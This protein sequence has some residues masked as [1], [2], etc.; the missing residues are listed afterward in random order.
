M[1]ITFHGGV[2]EVGGSCVVIETNDAKIAL[3][4]GIKVE[5]KLHDCLPKDLDLVI[6]SHAHLDHS[7]ALLSLAETNTVVV[8]SEATRDITVELLRDL[9]KVQRMNGNEIPYS[10]RDVA[11]IRR[12]WW[13]RD[14]VA[15]PGMEVRLYPAGH[16]LGARMVDIQAE[17]KEVLYTGDFCLHSTE[18]LEGSNLEK[19]PRE[20]EAL[21]VESTYGGTNRCNRPELIKRLFIEINE[22]MDRKGN[23]LIP[24]FAFHRSQEMAKR[25]D[26]AMWGGDFPNYNVYVISKLAERITGH[27][28]H[29]KNL[30]TE[31]IRG[32]ENPFNYKYV[33]NLHRIE[34]IVEPAI[35]ICTSGFGHAG[36]SRRLLTKW[37]PDR[38]NAILINSGYIPPESPLNVAREK[39]ELIENGIKVP[40]KADVKQIELSGHADQKELVKLVTTLKPNRTFLVHGDLKQ[41]QA[42][43]Q[44]ISNITHAEIPQKKEEYIL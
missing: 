38:N 31:E 37:A 30:L 36:A 22:A 44:K 17:G 7:G 42:L 8:G 23:V 34:Q 2:R 14:S 3:D 4:Y 29:H 20:P 13:V 21:I 27:F 41:A 26:T 10:N 32:Q 24:A 18:I 39:G 15:L 43:S 9:I 19:L 12:L 40:V 5:E 1:K 33:K 35:V 25:I 28:N 11:K 16:V 6:L